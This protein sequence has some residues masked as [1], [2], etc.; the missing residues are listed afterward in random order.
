MPSAI[1]PAMALDAKHV[2]W[3]PCAD[4]RTTATAAATRS[5]G[6]KDK[7]LGSITPEDQPSFSVEAEVGFNAARATGRCGSAGDTVGFRRP[8]HPLPAGG[9]GDRGRRD[10]QNVDLAAT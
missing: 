5:A 3:M 10:D 4:G 7:G 1:I 6:S 8:L 9:G 2:W